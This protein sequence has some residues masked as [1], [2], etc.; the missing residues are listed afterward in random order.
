MKAES[1][2]SPAEIKLRNEIRRSKRRLLAEA[3]ER[4]VELQAMV[5]HLESQDLTLSEEPNSESN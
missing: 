5:E 3:K 2:M 1:E 4:I